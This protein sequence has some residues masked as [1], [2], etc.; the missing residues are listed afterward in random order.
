MIAAITA[1]LEVV[2]SFLGFKTEEIKL[3]PTLEVVKDKKDLK[4]ASNITEEIIQL[5]DPYSETFD[6]SDL[7][8]YQK[9]KKEFL[10]HN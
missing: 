7:K 4:K 2:K 8:K 9:L 3:K 1:A 6:K 5:V 10:K